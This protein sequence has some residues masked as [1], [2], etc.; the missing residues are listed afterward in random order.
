M[1]YIARQS[2]IRRLRHRLFVDNPE[3]L[4]SLQFHLGEQLT[5]KKEIWAFFPLA[6]GYVAWSNTASSLFQPL[7]VQQVARNASRLASNPSLPCPEDDTLIS[8]GDRC[9]ESFGFSRVEPTSYVLLLN[10]VSVLCTIIV[11]LGTSAL[12]DHGRSSKK[13]LLCFCTLFAV[14]TAFMVIAPLKTELWWLAGLLMVIGLIFNGAT[15]NFYDAH[16]PILIR[17]HPRVVKAMVEFGE[18]SCEHIE[19]K[20][21]T[22]TFLSGEATSAGYAGGIVMTVLG[23]VLLMMMGTET[24]A[25]G[26]RMITS[27][28]FVLVFITIYGILSHQRTSPPLPTG[29]SYFTFGYVRIGKTTR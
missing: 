17:H 19:A 25:L 26:Y 22:A 27:A 4:I 16:I 10:A 13:L 29:V 9:L 5:K 28:I 7:L 14:T 2:R 24:T 12:A 1:C 15:L 3:D 23:A 6:F 20:T 21:K 11:S 8:N 18:N